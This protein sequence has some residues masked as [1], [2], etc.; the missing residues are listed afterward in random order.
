MGQSSTFRKSR[1]Q[2]QKRF[3]CLYVGKSGMTS[4][5]VTDCSLAMCKAFD[6]FLFRSL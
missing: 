4:I 2:T 1:Q 6:R 3:T 5:W